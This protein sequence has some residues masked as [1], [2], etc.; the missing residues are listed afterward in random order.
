PERA[1]LRAA[2]GRPTRGH[3]PG[4]E[5]DRRL[6]QLL[7]TATCGAEHEQRD[8]R[9]ADDEHRT[10]DERHRRRHLA[11]DPDAWRAPEQDGHRADRLAIEEHGGEFAEAKWRW[12]ARREAVVI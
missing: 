5:L 12:S 11:D 3:V 8:Q 1:P 4:A 7:Q 9:R 2:P 6:L 10:G